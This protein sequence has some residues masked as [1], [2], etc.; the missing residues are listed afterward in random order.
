[1]AK[2]KRLIQLH[3]QQLAKSKVQFE[4]YKEFIVK[5]FVDA[6]GSSYQRAEDLK[7]IWRKTFSFNPKCKKFLIEK[8]KLFI[9]ILP[10]DSK[11]ENIY[12][13][14][15]FLKS[16]IG[17]ISDYLSVYMCK[18]G[19]KQRNEYT[20]ELINILYNE[21][22]HVNLELGRYV[23][24]NNKEWGLQ[25]KEKRERQAAQ[26]KHEEEQKAPVI[27]IDIKIDPVQYS[28]MMNKKLRILKRELGYIK[29]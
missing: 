6:F 19:L 5:E 26:K 20:K 16:L 28:K 4:L 7:D 15:V 8:T 23:S 3:E 13:S 17:Q 10:L 22:K 18:E 11:G 25:Q 2:S 21:N 9:Y 1:M 29:S 14:P 24:R 27:T 12:Q